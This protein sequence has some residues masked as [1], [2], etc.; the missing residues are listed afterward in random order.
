[1]GYIR[2]DAIV[3]TGWDYNRVRKAHNKA[4]ELGLIVSGIVESNINGYFSLLIP[5]DGSKE[6]WDE[7][8]V[9]DTRR[10]EWK[11][12]AKTEKELWLDWVHI[13]YGGDDPEAINIVEYG[14]P[15]E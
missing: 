2:H 15:E 11:E 5:P 8:T 4:T 7:S 10:Q 1:M 9:G 13:N 12:W 14:D 6:G 3:V